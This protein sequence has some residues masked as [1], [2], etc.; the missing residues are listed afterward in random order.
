M[1]AW[2]RDPHQGPSL[3]DYLIFLVVVL[4]FMYLVLII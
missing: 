1:T 3:I 2:N 4:S